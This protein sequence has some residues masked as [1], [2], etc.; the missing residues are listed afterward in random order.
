MSEKFDLIGQREQRLE[1]ISTLRELGI[2]PYPSQA[3]KEYDNQ[4]VI[5]HFFDLDGK[6]VSG[7][8]RLMS[9]REHGKIM[10]GDVID[11]TG[12]LQVYVRIDDLEQDLTNGYLGWE[13][14]SLIDVGDFIQVEGE[15]TKTESGE[16]S[17]LAKHIKLLSKSLRPLPEKLENKE[18]RYRRRY[19]DLVVNPERRELFERKAK[20]WASHRG[21]MSKHGFIEIE[22]PVLE[23]VPGGADAAPFITHHNAL[24][25]DFYL[26]ISTE[27]YQKRLIGAGFEKIYTLGPNFRNEGISEQ[28]AQEF[29][30]IEW[31]WAYANYRDNMKFVQDIIRYVAQEVYGKTKFTTR[32][33]TFDLADDWKEIDYVEIIKETF[34]VDVFKTSSEE[35]LAILKK[36]SIELPGG[37]NRNRLI[38]N[39]WKLIRQNVSGPAFLVNEPTFMSPLAKTRENDPRIT[40]RFHVLIGG[41]ENG[42][43]YSEINNPLDQFERFAEQ[44]KMRDAGDDEAQMM[45]IDYVEMLEYGMPPTTGYGHS[46]RLF[47]FFEDITARE[48][49]LFPMMKFEISDTAKKI[50]G[51]Q[52]DFEVLEQAEDISLINQR[53]SGLPSRDEAEKLLVEYVKNE[54]QRLH[55]H[56]VALVME[57][58]AEKFGANKDL[59]Y[60]AG[61]LHDLDYDQYPD[62]HPHTE[63][64]WYEKWNYPE[65]LI[66]AIAAHGRHITNVEPKTKMAQAL[67]AVD[68]LSGF[69]YAYAQMREEGF[70]DMKASSIK[71]KLKDKSFAAKIDR[72][73]ILFGV[74]ALGIDLD[75]HIGLMISVFQLMSE[76]HK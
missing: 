53:L 45:D 8:G 71:K 72:G 20:F 29:Y 7:A 75:E 2:N 21:F 15:V 59:W 9:W 49:A 76:L 40:E 30:Q 34:G 4:Y 1:K 11:Q 33:Y 35:I 62:K 24:D 55:V 31:Y 63:L 43:G 68:E 57:K 14:L 5:D 65:P 17:I 3:K 48:G 54:Y 16:I 74:E 10:F 73:E 60:I 37:I 12:K 41:S 39:L 6:I 67:L 42:N 52:L 18:E 27:L 66:H 19:L 38:D 47:W 61:L 44:Q 50:Y 64:E 46:E 70:V 58:Y 23:H 25:S 22:V 32:G 51:N 26:R 36:N 69:M 28:H 13:E 56:M